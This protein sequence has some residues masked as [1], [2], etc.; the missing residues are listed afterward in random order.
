MFTNP[1]GCSLAPYMPNIELTGAASETG[2]LGYFVVGARSDPAAMPMACSRVL[3]VAAAVRGWAGCAE[4]GGVRVYSLF[5]GVGVFHSSD[6]SWRVERVGSGTAAA[7]AAST[8]TLMGGKGYPRNRNSLE[9]WCVQPG[10]YRVHAYDNNAVSSANAS[11]GWDGGNLFF[12]DA[13]GC[14]LTDITV[15]MSASFGGA[16]IFSNTKVRTN[17]ATAPTAAPCSSVVQV[18]PHL[19]ITVSSS[20]FFLAPLPCQN[21]T[22]SLGRRAHAPSLAAVR[23][24]KSKWTSRASLARRRTGARASSR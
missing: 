9:E 17:Y 13:S 5:Y 15:D 16:D 12:L 14:I 3:D 18:T 19:R 22:L 24:R 4:R 11:H 23:G 21:R 8:P 20:Q 6:V 1:S 10:S 2:V 7:A